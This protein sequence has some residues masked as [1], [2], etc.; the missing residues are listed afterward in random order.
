M[1]NEREKVF[2]VAKK[3]SIKTTLLA[4]IV[5]ELFIVGINIVMYLNYKQD[6]IVTTIACQPFIA[7][8]ALLINK[9][10]MGLN[11]QE[12]TIKLVDRLLPKGELIDVILRQ[13]VQY[14]TLIET[15]RKHC[16]CQF[17]AL[18]TE[19][20]PEKVQIVVKFPEQTVSEALL[21]M[22]KYEFA[23]N[24]EVITEQD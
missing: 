20:E 21:M 11:L 22:E 18:I 17:F 2:E 10:N 23:E 19:K 5:M 7:L 9:F 24:F 12:E 14:W 15:L 4:I 1:Q 6:I 3:R 16:H 13:K 8:F